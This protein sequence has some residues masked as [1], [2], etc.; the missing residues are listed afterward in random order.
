MNPVKMGAMI[1]AGAAAAAAA[2][3][4]I[5]VMYRRLRKENF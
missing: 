1:A 2:G 5:A 3:A 4:A